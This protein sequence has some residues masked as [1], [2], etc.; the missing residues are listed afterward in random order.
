[1]KNKLFITFAVLI[2]SN[3]CFSQSNVVTDG[4]GDATTNYVMKWEDGGTYK[5]KNGL[6]YDDGTNVGLGTTSML[7]IFHIA[8]TDFNTSRTII[9]RSSSQGW[10]PSLDLV[11]KSSDGSYILSGRALGYLNFYGEYSADA[12]AAGATVRAYTTQNWGV[13]GYGSKLEFLTVP[14]SST[15]SYVRMTINQDGAVQFNGS[16]SG[17]VGLKPPAVAGSTTYTLPSADGSAGQVLKT[18]GSGILSWLTPLI[19]S[20]GWSTTGNSGLTAGTNFVGTTDAVDLVFKVNSQ[21]SG[22]IDD[23]GPT[24]LG[25]QAGNSNTAT[26]STGFGYQALYSNTTG[27]ANTAFGISSLYSNTTGGSNTAIGISSLYTN[28]TGYFNTATGYYSLYL[29]TTGHHNTATGYWALYSNTTGQHNTAIGY[30]AIN[31][32]TTG[33]YNS[34]LGYT[35][36]NYTTTG[37]YNTALGYAADANGDYSNATVIGRSAVV[38]ASNYVRVGNTSVTQIGGEVGWTNLSD[39][40]FK[41]NVQENVKGLDFI[42]KLRPVTFQLDSKAADD[43]LIQNMPDSVKLMHQ[44]GMD[45]APATAMIHSGF[46]AQEVEQAETECGFTSSIVNKPANDT[47]PYSLVYAE[48]VV[49]LVKAVQELS[50]TVDSLKQHQLQTDSLLLVLQNS[51]PQGT[52]NKNLQNTGSLEQ[53]NSETTLQV[54][55][56]NNNQAILYQNEPNPFSSSTVIRYFIPEDITGSTYIVFYDM[57]GKELHKAEITTKGFGKVDTNTE[58]LTSGMYSYSLIINDK[59]IETKKMI[60]SK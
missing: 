55:L 21:K 43:F 32:N 8:G 45:F 16:T 10:G 6:L 22:L 58:K 28:T 41:F 30:S 57:Y 20:T 4:G 18:D 3:Y 1:M 46:I 49:P 19:S 11:A 48:I 31:N 37:S 7:G 54:E 53:G 52:I 40:R 47:D 9:Q 14:N 35:A 36:L 34:T 50:K 2:F 51:I 59:T 39:G 60:K 24:F 29:N 38:S 42:K 15:T 17:Y 5:A 13:S 33:S 12:I 27:A 44:A 23:G 56:A 25:Y 26:S